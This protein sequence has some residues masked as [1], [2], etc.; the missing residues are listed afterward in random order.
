MMTLYIYLQVRFNYQ[1]TNKSLHKGIV[2]ITEK[3]H[4]MDSV[5]HDEAKKSHRIS[6]ILHNELS[7]LR[8]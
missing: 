8:F 4:L 7:K 6:N 3:C 1:P 2:E 5:R